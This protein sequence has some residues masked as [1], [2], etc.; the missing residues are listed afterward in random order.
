MKFFGIAS[1]ALLSVSAANSLDCGQ[2]KVPDANNICIQPNFIEG[3]EVYASKFACHQCEAGNIQTNC[4]LC[5][6]GW[7]MQRR[8]VRYQPRIHEDC[9]MPAKRWGWEGMR[10]LRNR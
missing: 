10:K 5:D 3:C 8:Y 4:R 7:S 2:G 9:G 1:L 6:S